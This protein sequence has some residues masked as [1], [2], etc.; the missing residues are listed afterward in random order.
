MKSYFKGGRTATLEFGIWGFPEK[1]L[2]ILDFADLASL[3]NA[4][5]DSSLVAGLSCFKL[6]FFLTG[7]GESP[8]PGRR[9]AEALAAYTSGCSV[10]SI[11]VL[12]S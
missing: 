6:A 7:E 5:F 10:I 1:G 8:G 2:Y 11:G 3:V 9:L 4:F 12:T